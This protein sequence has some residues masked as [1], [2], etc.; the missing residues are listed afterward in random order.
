MTESLLPARPL[1]PDGPIGGEPGALGLGAGSGI[2]I[3]RTE[4]PADIAEMEALIHALDGREGMYYGCD[5]VA[6][7]PFIRRTTAFIDA[8]LTLAFA[9]DILRLIPHGAL[10][11]GLAGFWPN[12]W[13]CE[14]RDGTGY[15]R[16]DRG[17]KP[18][19][20]PV[21]AALRAFM[22][23]FGDAPAELGLYGAWNFD[24]YRLAAGNEGTPAKERSPRFTLFIPNRMLVSDGA[25]A[26]WISYAFPDLAAGADP[27]PPASPESF[28]LQ[29]EPTPADDFAPGKYAEVVARA[30]ERIQDGE[31]VSMTLAQSF[32]RPFGGSPAAAFLALRKTYPMPEMFFLH[33]PQ[34]EFIFGASPD[35]QVR[36]H[37]GVVECAPVCGTLPRGK[38]PIEDMELARELLT[39]DKEGA[40]LALCSDHY[41]NT[42]AKVCMPGSVELVT[43]RR[44]HYFASVIHAVDH[45]RGCAR[46]DVD[47]LDVLLAFAAPGVVSGIPQRAA[48][49]AIEALEASPRGWF[50]G[51]VGHLDCD[52]TLAAGTILRSAW[53]RGGTAEVRTGGVIVANS[54]PPSEEA[55]THVK[56]NT[57]FRLLGVL[58]PSA[59]VA[60]GSA[61]AGP[62]FEC[63]TLH[64]D[65]DPLGASLLDFLVRLG[66]SVATA[67]PAGAA[68]EQLR[69]VSDASTG[70]EDGDVATPIVWIGAA[71]LAR[72]RAAGVAF[73][74]LDPP[75]YAVPVKAQSGQDS[76]LESLCP[77]TLGRYAAQLM[78]R[79]D[80]PPSW[81]AWLV[82]DDGSVL[83]A[84]HA[85]LPQA[86]L[87]FRPDSNVSL[88][89]R[90]GERVFLAALN[91]LSSFV[92]QPSADWAVRRQSGQHA[93]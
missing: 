71:A 60:T 27:G 28:E 57:L 42:L 9:D 11:A 19:P 3:V 47:A 74:R 48:L 81:Q 26:R 30:V 52:G 43:K 63:A 23:R 53:L 69:V 10:G 46:S 21:I 12:A 36:I 93:Q 41:R 44:P 59:G 40:A 62:A 33:M 82:A 5:Y 22:R 1:R 89:H 67:G 79:E 55:E 39:S 83:V 51:A 72:L 17:D 7:P 35:M 14:W 29:A 61:N 91:E 92:G 77:L 76:R 37:D 20:H 86:A 75:Q 56:A 8:P 73:R 6:G 64:A 2:A 38:D 50:G 4:S 31:I 78:M 84:G 70:P 85:S 13:P 34:R 18:G 80:L 49:D 45:L 87:L 32:R 88:K 15:V 66:I 25:T 24:Y 65:S 58:P 16:F 54:H 68:K 90:A